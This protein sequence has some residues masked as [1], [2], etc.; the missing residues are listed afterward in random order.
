MSAADTITTYS[1]LTTTGQ[2]TIIRTYRLV[3]EVF[4]QTNQTNGN[5][6]STAPFCLSSIDFSGSTSTKFFT[7]LAS[8]VF[9]V[10]GLVC[11]F[12]FVVRPFW[13]TK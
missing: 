3:G 2:N 10:I 7:E 8:I 5:F 4:Y 1:N 11:L 9:I 6:P 13:R 12:K